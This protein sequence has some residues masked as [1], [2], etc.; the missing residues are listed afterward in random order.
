MPPYPKIEILDSS[1][2]KEP[3]CGEKDNLIALV[4]NEKIKSSVPTFSSDQIKSLV[5][6]LENKI[7]I[8]RKEK[9]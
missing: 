3:L 9:K 8:K 6:F 1:R 5:D 2:D 4:S 7:G